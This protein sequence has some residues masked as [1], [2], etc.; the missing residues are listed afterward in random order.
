MCA[1]G[2][3]SFALLSL[4][5]LIQSTHRFGE[6]LLLAVRFEAMLFKCTL[7]PLNQYLL[8]GSLFLKPK[9]L[10]FR[11]NVSLVMLVGYIPAGRNAVASL[12]TRPGLQP[13][14]HDPLGRGAEVRAG[15]RPAAG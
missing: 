2:S 12:R 4:H 3:H 9:V 14:G 7:Q 15:A 1:F 10:Q 6:A 8:R 5:E 13:F 11:P